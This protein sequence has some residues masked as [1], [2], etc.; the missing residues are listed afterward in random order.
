MYTRPKNRGT[1]VGESVVQTRRKPLYTKA[2]MRGTK[3]RASVVQKSP[4]PLYKLERMACTNSGEFHV[5]PTFCMGFAPCGDVQMLAKPLYQTCR[6]RCTKCAEAV[7]HKRPN[8]LYEMVQFVP[9]FRRLL[10][11][12]IGKFCTAGS[13]PSVHALGGFMYM[14]WRGSCTWFVGVHVHRLRAFMYIVW[15]AFG[16]L[17]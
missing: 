8:A 4:K 10:Y 5:F 1:K 7:V 9:P 11:N 2:R 3:M 13:G 6:R 17:V 14:V 12:G 15:G 16:A